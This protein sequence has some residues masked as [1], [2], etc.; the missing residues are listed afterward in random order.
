MPR[1]AVVLCQDAKS[2]FTLRTVLA[3]MGIDPVTCNSQEDALDQILGKGCTALVVDFD[4]PGAGKVAKLAGL[5]EASQRPALMAMTTAWPG[6]GQAFQSGASRILYKP[7][8]T[9]QIR[10]AFEAAEKIAKRDNREALRYK[11][12]SVVWLDLATGTLPAVAVNLS[13]HGMAI[14][15][16]ERL[17][18]QSNV[19]FRC[20]L[21]GRDQIHGHA[22]VIWSD[23]DGRAGMFFSRFSPSAKKHLKDWLMDREKK[24][25]GK[26]SRARKM[27]AKVLKCSNYNSVRD[28]LPPP[29]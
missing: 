25:P 6:S 7:L 14:R 8:Q 16:T 10:D 19:S 28:L 1:S 15:T 12:T 3:Q 4:L 13:E 20:A 24:L 21:P 5:V 11:I 27:A 29:G 23:A 17:R 18:L 26:S 22:D 9:A 2:L